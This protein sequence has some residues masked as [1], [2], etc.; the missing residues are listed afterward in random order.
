MGTLLDGFRRR[1]RKAFLKYSASQA[2][3]RSTI[4]LDNQQLPQQ[5]QWTQKRSKPVSPHGNG[6]T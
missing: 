4:E 1:C 2:G 3:R 6:T 5:G